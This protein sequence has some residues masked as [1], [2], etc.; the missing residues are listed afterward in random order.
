MR[1]LEAAK[2][3]AG[4]FLSKVTFVSL[5]SVRGKAAVLKNEAH[6]APSE[7]N[8]PYLSKLLQ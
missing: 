4:K 3:I 1:D 6:S 5:G 2:Q 8:A 7:R